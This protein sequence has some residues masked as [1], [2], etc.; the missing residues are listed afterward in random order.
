MTS[1][2]LQ[3]ISTH[4]RYTVKPQQTTTTVYRPSYCVLTT[5]PTVSQQRISHCNLPKTKDYMFYGNTCFWSLY[6]PLKDW[7]NLHLYG[8]SNHLY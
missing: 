1:D 2:P 4:L 3:S 6:G 8:I 7:F 5:M